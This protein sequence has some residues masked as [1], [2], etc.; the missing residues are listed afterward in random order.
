M[1][2]AALP[3]WRTLYAGEAD[4]LAEDGQEARDNV[5]GV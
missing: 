2:G 5:D 3:P 1:D 4:C